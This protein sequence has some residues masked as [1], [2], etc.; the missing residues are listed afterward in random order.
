MFHLYCPI[1]NCKVSLNK[2]NQ[3]Y[4]IKHIR[5]HI[6]FQKIDLPF[7]CGQNECQKTFYDVNIYS[8]HLNKYH[9]YN[10][11]INATNHINESNDEIQCMESNE[12]LENSDDPT[13]NF[14]DTHQDNASIKQ[15]QFYNLDATIK[16]KAFDLINNLRAK[17]QISGILLN[18]II[19]S[20]EDFIFDLI[21][22]IQLEMFEFF[23]P[24][25]NQKE[26]LNE[27]FS[28]VSNP[29]D[30][31]STTYKQQAHLVK[32]GFYVAPKTVK[33]GNRDDISIVDGEPYV[34]EKNVSFQYVSILET[35]QM[36]LRNSEFKKE[37]DKYSNC[38]DKYFYYDQHPLL[39]N[40]KNLRILL[41]YDDLEIANALGDV[42][43][44]Y[45][46][47]MFYFTLLNLT[48]RHYSSLKNIYLVATCHS[49]DL[50]KFG[51]NK[52]LDLIIRDIKQI[53]NIGIKI[54]LETYFGTIAQC[55]GDNLG[56][57]QIFGIQQK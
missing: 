34:V 51:Y 50:K 43:G 32:T 17:N 19:D 31:F 27:L 26:Y 7:T 11:N 2:K 44:I 47:G 56:I 40:K 37:V 29:F 52:V 36:L 53:E 45:K 1:L 42:S 22:L 55:L 14:T 23:G 20:F 12:N 13:E 49:D 28:K 16:S 33:L 4:L 35:I 8:N 24:S 18:E 39:A 30:C 10:I 57:H 46:C 6:Q 3:K 25:D 21:E 38:E 15:N 48:R 9:I 5:E 41:Y 54:D